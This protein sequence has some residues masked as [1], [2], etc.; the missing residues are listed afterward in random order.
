MRAKSIPVVVIFFIVFIIGFS[1][2]VAASGS[3]RW[4]SFEEGMALG[5]NQN[6]KIFIHFTAE[7]CYFCTQMEKSTF[8]DPVVISA[9]NE[10]Y[11]PIRVDYDRE[12]ET[13][14]MF[15][16]KG[17]PDTWFIAEDGEVI[18]HRPGYISAEQLKT[19]LNLLMQES[20][21]E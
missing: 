6:K 3:I 14:S 18:G 2:N 12:K 21:A 10:N 20:S 15:R 1:S 13:S 16:V 5:K 4:L 19:I 17:L 11:I 7:W 9:L 8:S